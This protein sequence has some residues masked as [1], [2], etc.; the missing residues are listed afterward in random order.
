MRKTLFEELKRD[1]NYRKLGLRQV[2]AV[3]ILSIIVLVFVFFGYSAK[4]SLGAGAVA[5]VN[6]TVVSA[7]EY[8]RELSRLEKMYSSIIKQLGSGKQQMDFLR[9]QALDNIINHE[10]AFQSAARLGIQVS[11]AE[12]VKVITQDF[13]AF[14]DE[15]KFTRE[16]Y[17]GVLRAN[18]WTPSEFEK[19]IKKEKAIRRFQLMTEL[20]FAPSALELKKETQLSEKQKNIEFVSWDMAEW[21]KSVKPS[22]QEIRELLKDATF[23]EKVQKEF[24]SKKESLSQKEQVRA[25]HIL[26][27]FE[28][29]AQ[30]KDALAKIKS[31][32]DQL[33]S[34]DF[35]L[36]ARQFSEDEGSKNKGGDLG[37][38]SRGTMVAE[39][40]QYA[41]SADVNKVSDPIKTQ[42]GYHLIQVTDKKKAKEANITEHEL[43]LAGE[44]WAREHYESEVKRLEEL[45]SARNFK[46]VEAIIQKWGLKWQESGF[47][48]LADEVAGRL[49][50]AVAT[51]KAWQLGTKVTHLDQLVRDGGRVYY[52]RFKSEQTNKKTDGENSA[53]KLAQAKSSEVLGRFLQEQKERSKIVKNLQVLRN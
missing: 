26:I 21:S 35:G 3:T 53:Q 51:E 11:K 17:E 7:A 47:F 9:S 10:V 32:Q 45:L 31:I 29:E 12:I 22:V 8:Q 14:Q 39:F 5:Q 2:F 33:R 27:K 52:L 49:N 13:T 44:V 34:K 50:S 38:F 42:Y 20:A 15:G 36:L 6:S 46:E 48:S 1:L 24:E 18:Q 40:E 25:R 23:K 43:S 16:R 28:S 41:F 19:Q 4:D 37:Y 30:E